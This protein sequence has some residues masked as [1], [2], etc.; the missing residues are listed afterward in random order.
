MAYESIVEP[1]RMLERKPGAQRA[2][3]VPT[4]RAPVYDTESGRVIGFRDVFCPELVLARLQR[5]GF[6]LRARGTG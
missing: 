5:H 4:L 3:Y 2:E 1:G 6:G